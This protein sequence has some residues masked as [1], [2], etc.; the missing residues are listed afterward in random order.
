M[1]ALLSV[2]ANIRHSHMHMEFKIMEVQ[3]MFRTIKMYNKSHL[4]D[5]VKEETA[6][7]AS[8]LMQKWNDLRRDAN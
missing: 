1:K 5:E 4:N 6:E 2:I 3:E 7:D 8:S